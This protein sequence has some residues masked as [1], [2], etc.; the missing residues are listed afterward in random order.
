MYFSKEK[1]LIVRVKGGLGNQLFCYAA[2]K[3][4]A[5]VNSANLVLDN[6]SAFE[7]DIV[8]R[9]TFQLDNF[10]IDADIATPAQRLEP[11]KEIRRKILRFLGKYQ[12]FENRKYIFQQENPFD[13]RLLHLR[14]N[15]TR[16]LVLAKR[17]VFPG[18]RR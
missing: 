13:E 14:F 3:R 8:Y 4:L 1:N 7:N 6:I 9:H 17:K 11:F 5:K 16:Y 18:S 12:N 10:N 2:G 15:S